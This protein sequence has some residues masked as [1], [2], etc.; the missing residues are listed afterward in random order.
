MRISPPAQTSKCVYISILALLI[1]FAGILTPLSAQTNSTWIGGSSG[2][3]SDAANWSNGVPNGNYDVLIPSVSGF[4]TINLD[5]NAT[6]NELNIQDTLNITSNHSLT[7]QAGGAVTLGTIELSGGSIIEASP[8]GRLEIIAGNP[9][10]RIA[11]S[12]TIQ[13]ADVALADVRLLLQS[14]NS[15]SATGNVLADAYG[16]SIAAGALL[17]IG[18]SYTNAGGTEITGGTMMVRGDVT[19]TRDEGAFF[20][21]TNGGI[22]NVGGTF[23]NVTNAAS[24]ILNISGGSV[25]NVAQDLNNHNG[26]MSAAAGIVITDGSALNVKG[27]VNNGTAMLST[28]YFSLGTGSTFTVQKG[29]NNFGTVTLSTGS[30]GTVNGAVNNAGS[31]QID[32]TSALTAK[33]G[34]N[35]TAGSTQVDGILSAQGAGLSISGGTLSGSG[36]V[37]GNLTNGGSVGDSPGTLTI[38]GNYTQTS[39]GS[40]IEEV[41][42]INGMNASLLQVNGTATL[43]GTLV[44]SLLGGYNPGVGDSFILMTFLQ[45]YGSFNTITGLNPGNNEYLQLFYDPHDVRVQVEQTPEPSSMLLLVV[46]AIAVVFAAK[47]AAHSV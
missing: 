9:V 43:D 23:N 6:V 41:G 20:T 7:I 11:G 15:L 39:S 45:G 12:G 5:M 35:Q 29:L 10:A 38:K 31:V 24:G 30:A 33:T 8:T 2:N 4:S 47:R 34:F 14:G 46:G 3:W 1:L 36:I 28:E 32:A 21:V 42:W 37:V 44:L 13:A 19:N 25:V 26:D 18:G 17:G 27:T 16:N 40:L 22:V